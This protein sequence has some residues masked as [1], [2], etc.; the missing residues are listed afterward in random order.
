MHLAVCCL[1]CATDI[2]SHLDCPDSHRYQSPDATDPPRGPQT[3]WQGGLAVAIIIGGA[4]GVNDAILKTRAAVK[5]RNSRR[6]RASQKV[7]QPCSR[8]RPRAAR[9]SP[10]AFASAGFFVSS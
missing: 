9:H 7:H 8:K 6:V 10:P 4:L 3:Q 2:A 5:S 1:R